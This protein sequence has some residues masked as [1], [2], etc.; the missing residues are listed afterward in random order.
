MGAHDLQEEAFF[1]REGDVG[2]GDVD[3]ADG[4][5]FGRRG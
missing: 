3:E 1:G 2:V 5:V 4:G